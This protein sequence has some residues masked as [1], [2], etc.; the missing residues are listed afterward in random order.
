VI[1]SISDID[2]AYAERSGIG[3]VLHGKMHGAL[4]KNKCSSRYAFSVSVVIAQLEITMPQYAS[5]LSTNQKLLLA[6]IGVILWFVAA[7]LIRL[8]APMG[9]YA[10]GW[11]FLNYALI[12]PGTAPIIWIIKKQMQLGA[13]Q[14]PL[15]VSIITAAA[16]VMDGIAHGWFPALY[17]ADPV[18][19]VKG[20]GAI[21]WG[22]GIGL[23][24]S[25]VM[26]DAPKP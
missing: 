6:V 19:G 8:L 2:K 16:L 9:A 4:S 23:I 22:A 7:M 13:G 12:V 15:A 10:G 17:S 21:F 18:L 3:Q 5:A 1:F 20:A 11:Q 24:L 25:F 26:D 14:L